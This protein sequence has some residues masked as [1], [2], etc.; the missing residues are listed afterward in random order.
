M[1][2]TTRLSANEW[3]ISLLIG[4]ASLPVGM[5]LRLT[6]DASLQRIFTFRV[7]TQRSRETRASD[8]SEGDQ[9]HRAI[10]NVRFK[11]GSRRQPRSSRLERLRRGILPFVKAKLFGVAQD[12]D[13]EV[14]EISPLLPFNSRQDLSRTGSI[15]APAAAVMAGIVAGGVAGWPRI[16]DET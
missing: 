5:L 16:P 3:A 8:A 9:W 15:C 13:G 10:E 4:F 7:G 12:D 14:D 11:L 2:A 1:L 6:P